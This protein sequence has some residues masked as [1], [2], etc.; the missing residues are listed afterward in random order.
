[1]VWSLVTLFLQRARVLG[2]AML[3]ATPVFLCADV[4]YRVEFSG[5]VDVETM[6]LLRSH[7]QLLS[8]CERSP[9]TL[10][11]LQRRA[12]ADIPNLI[13]A[14]HSL[15]FYNADIELNV[16]TATTPATVHIHVETGCPFQLHRYRVLSASTLITAA[17][18]IPTE[19]ILEYGQLFL[20]Q[21][22]LSS[23]IKISCPAAEALEE[24]RDSEY[25]EGD[26][27][28]SNY[29]NLAD[30]T[31][32][33]LGLQ[34]GMTALPSAILKAEETL[35]QWINCQ[36][37]PLAEVVKREVIADQTECTVTVNLYVKTGPL[38]YLAEP[39]VSGNRD[40]CNCYIERKIGWC[41]GD[42]YTP[43]TIACTFDKLER[44]GLFRSI[45]IELG[46]ELNEDG[47][48]PVDVL[49][50]E[51]RHRTIGLGISYST[52]FGAG[53][54][55]EWEHRNIRGMGETLSAQAEV[56]QR[57]QSG[58]ITYR[59]PD[60]FWE[61]TDW[62]LGFEG[63]REITESF[64]E[65]SLTAT[66]RLYRRL[67]SCLQGWAG[68]AVMYTH[69]TDSDNDKYF[70]LGKI[71]LQLRYSS[72]N[73]LL[74]PCYGTA[75]NLK[76]T[77]TAPLWFPS[78]FYYPI[79]YDGAVYVPV[80]SSCSWILAGKLSLASI[81]GA[82]RLDIPPPER[83]Y[84]GSPNTLRGY[85]YL[86]VSPINEETGKP[87]GGRSLLVVSMESRHRITETWGFVSFWEIGNVYR[88]S[89]PKIKAKQLQSAGF[90][91]RYY[92][93]VGPLRLDIAFP[94][95]RRKVTK[96]KSDGKTKTKTIDG[97]VQ[98]YFSIGQTY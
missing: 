24:E 96:R 28:A 36:G 17:E 37:Y 21:N 63:D 80:W 70:L 48:L 92:T 95:D 54:I 89:V 94:L 51:G 88:T 50:S 32:E 12:R 14:L 47:L 93:P 56:L 97:P 11:S 68:L 23:Y 6:A 74:D 22:F 19:K 15:G 75:M 84:A 27:C 16:D 4:P 82:S 3:L 13:Q 78:D 35:M 55:G 81:M 41:E 58:E 76:F 34:V 33:F 59:K 72:A 20:R 77:P 62:L 18:A 98:F 38:A 71:P 90:G 43:E 26:Y 83:L 25:E 57:F 69:S 91:L 44:T 85:P 53:F 64:H 42:L 60:C 45:N 86:S 2:L 30:V 87:E 49:L 29:L 79:R 73:N 39:N 67:S 8:L 5:H 52:E 65:R 61:G 66:S 1:M 40:V 7:S 31:E 10:T 46:S 9:E